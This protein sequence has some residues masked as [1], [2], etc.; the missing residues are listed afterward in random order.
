MTLVLSE[1]V[2][3][4]LQQKLK[5][6]TIRVTKVNAPGSGY[7]VYRKLAHRTDGGR[8]QHALTGRTT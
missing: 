1:S 4:E 7:T 3:R 2:R 8:N 6:D 5:F